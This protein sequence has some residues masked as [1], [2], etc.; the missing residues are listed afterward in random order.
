[1]AKR[2][3]SESS[4]DNQVFKGS[5]KQNGPNIW[6]DEAHDEI[7]KRW[8]AAD[9]WGLYIYVCVWGSINKDQSNNGGEHI[10]G[11]AE[12]TIWNLIFAGYEKLMQRFVSVNG[13]IVS[14]V[15]KINL[16]TYIVV[17]LGLYTYEH[18]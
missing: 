7:I 18:F 14:C 16:K 2:K 8:T 17:H 11:N 12:V 13:I 10:Y 6:V 4:E 15:R 1:M 5:G 9:G 3:Y